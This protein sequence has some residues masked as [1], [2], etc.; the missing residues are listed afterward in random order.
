MRMRQYL[1][2]PLLLVV[3]ALSGNA[4]A[5]DECAAEYAGTRAPLPAADAQF[6][7]KAIASI[8][9]KKRQEL[10][11]ILDAKLT[12]VRRLMSGAA[13]IKGG[14][15]NLYLKP[16]QLDANMGIHLPATKVP[17][18][19]W[20]PDPELI[21]IPAHTLTDFSDEHFNPETDGTGIIMGRTICGADDKC[22]VLPAYS[23]LDFLMSGLLRCN[24]NKA[25]AFVFSDG[26]LLTDMELAPSP[27]GQALF[28]AKRQD[29]Y[30][31]AAFIIYG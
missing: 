7:S 15:L 31:L 28:F 23:E 9:H 30:K 10:L 26:L 21:T 11:P 1:Y 2:V 20:A 24:K 29:G 5:D 27:V 8:K 12:L 6:L 17:D 25:A 3:A 13:G 18:I 4:L 16:Q 19:P 14:D 22:D